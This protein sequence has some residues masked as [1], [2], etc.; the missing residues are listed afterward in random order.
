LAARLGG[1]VERYDLNVTFFGDD[2]L[3][4]RDRPFMGLTRHFAHIIESSGLRLNE[5]KTLPVAG[6]SE[7]HRALGVTMN[8]F[9]RE[10]DVPRAYRRKLRTLIYIVQRY[11]PAALREFGITNSDPHEYLRGKIAFAVFVNPRN[12]VFEESLKRISW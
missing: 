9:G 3:I 8:A 11:G 10:I 1:L 6:P 7:K 12:K 2:I 4:S 5:E